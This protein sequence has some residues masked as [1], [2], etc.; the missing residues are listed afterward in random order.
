[1]EKNFEK[2]TNDWLQLEV[3]YD[4]GK[5]PRNNKIYTKNFRAEYAFTAK[6]YSKEKTLKLRCQYPLMAGYEFK[7]NEEV[8]NYFQSENCDTDEE[9]R[10]K[11]AKYLQKKLFEIVSD[12]MREAYLLNYNYVQAVVNESDEELIEEKLQN[13]KTFVSEHFEWKKVRIRIKFSILFCN[14]N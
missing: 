9:S 2:H 5:L 8:V 12:P 6:G 13:F 7:T 4:A 3:G 1:L 11:I 14:T 10:E